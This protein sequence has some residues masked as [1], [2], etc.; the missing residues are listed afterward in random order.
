[1]S[2][3]N[4]LNVEG[5]VRQSA[6]LGKWY[7][8]AASVF[9]S[10]VSK[11]LAPY[12]RAGC[13]TC[14]HIFHPLVPCLQLR[15]RVPPGLPLEASHLWNSSFL[16]TPTEIH[17]Q[18]TWTDFLNSSCMLPNVSVLHNSYWQHCT[19]CLRFKNRF[20]KIISLRLQVCI[21]SENSWLFSVYPEAMFPRCL[22]HPGIS[23]RGPTANTNHT[24]LDT[25]AHNSCFDAERQ[26][27]YRSVPSSELQCHKIE[28]ES[29]NSS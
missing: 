1:M 11:S 5:D 29:S 19:P 21:F 17:L 10:D 4:A 24:A 18:G 14:G 26:I 9:V 23:V 3:D 15:Q 7:I 16:K 20:Y 27:L 6:K 25:H 8:S 2:A 28:W 13:P 12:L 22:Q